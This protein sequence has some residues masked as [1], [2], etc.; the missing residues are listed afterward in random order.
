MSRRKNRSFVF[1]LIAGMVTLVTMVRTA[2]PAG[3]PTGPE[4]LQGLS[5]TI[6]NADDKDGKFDTRPARLLAL[7]VAEGAAPTPFLRSGAFKATW[8]GDLNLRLRERMSFHAEGRGKLTISLK[9]KTVFEAAG[10]DLSQKAGDVVRLDKGAN[11][12]LVTYESPDKGDALVRVYWKEQKG[13]RAEPIP[14]TAFTHDP[15]AKGEAEGVRLREGRELVANLRCTKCHTVA[16]PGA[17]AAMPELAMDAPA[18][19][20]V[21]NRLDSYWVARWVANPRNFREDTHMPKVVPDDA[22]AWDVAG[23]LASLRP[24]RTQP[25]PS[26]RRLAPRGGQLF[27]SLNCVGCHTPPDTVDVAPNDPR[28][29]LGNV[30]SKFLPH[31]LAEYLVNPHAHY[32]WNPMPNFGLDREEAD[33]LAAYLFEKSAKPP[34]IAPPPAP[35]VEHGRQLV[36][37]AGCLNCHTVEKETTTLKA[38][39]L[40]AIPASS[41]DRGCMAADAAGRKSAPDFGLSD[42]QRAALRAFAATDRTSLSRDDPAEFAA[43]QVAA[44]R[45]TACHARDGK[46]ALVGTDF[47]AD[48]AL[49]NAAYP[50]PPQPPGA[51]ARGE[52]MA[53]DQ[54]PPM[55]TW[56]GEK[57]RPEWA[58]A[59]IAGK[60]TYKPR[61]YLL[62]RMPAWPTRAEGLARGLAAEHGFSPAT[63]PYPKPD[64]QLA[65]AGQKLIGA[66]GGFQCVQCH[67]VGAQ[68]PMAPFEAPALNFAYV[69]ERL[70]KEHYLRWVFNP[71]KVDPSTKMP[72]FADADGKTPLRDTFEGDAGKQFDAIWQFL[73]KGKDVKPP[74]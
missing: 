43:R 68:P 53:A 56:A 46:E 64:E 26:D 14:P 15:S 23:Y 7:H 47:A 69:S 3:A 45:C 24:V 34:Q 73:L 49:L 20:D 30:V 71:I 18:L 36:R 50:P 61:P 22:A 59:F 70:R 41:W 44:M 55:L 9:G 31:A 32:A 60:I 29:P 12:L 67:A 1:V 57:L 51:E 17:A 35:N 21:G 58:S 4:P 8:S 2:R 72:A 19:T 39:D 65:R 27:A 5:L 10:D 62:A 6:Q 66:V 40:V 38:P 13:L 11:A 63:L 28:V 54:R 52:V 37:S 42:D 48:Q 33:S 16:P 25:P 74:P